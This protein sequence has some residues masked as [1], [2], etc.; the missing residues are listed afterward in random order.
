MSPQSRLEIRSIVS[1]YVGER[2]SQPAKIYV[3]VITSKEKRLDRTIEA[4]SLNHYRT[5]SSLQLP[6]LGSNQ[7]SPDPESGNMECPGI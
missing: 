1:R 2:G 5:T 4:S 6:L 3:A 7:D